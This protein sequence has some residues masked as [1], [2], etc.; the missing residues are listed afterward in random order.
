MNYL[1]AAYVAFWVLVFLFIV[2]L[3]SRQRNLEKAVEVLE[4]RVEHL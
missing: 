3:K 2:S 4:K 1:V